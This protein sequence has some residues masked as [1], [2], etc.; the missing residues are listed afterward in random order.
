MDQTMQDE[1]EKEKEKK[2]EEH[3]K[4]QLKFTQCLNASIKL[5]AL[6]EKKKSI[7]SI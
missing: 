7:I 1:E 2:I 6:R 3:T 4:F 5:R